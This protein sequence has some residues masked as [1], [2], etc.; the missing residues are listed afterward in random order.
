MSNMKYLVLKNED[1]ERILRPPVAQYIY[2]LAATIARSRKREGKNPD[3]TYLVVNTD[4]LYAGAVADLIESHERQKGTWDHG[5]KSLREVMR[6]PP[7][8]FKEGE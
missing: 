2:E 6:I 5:G 1:I 4:E 7:A 8:G 3:N